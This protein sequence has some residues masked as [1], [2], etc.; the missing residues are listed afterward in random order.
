MAS[1]EAKLSFDQESQLYTLRS[2]SYSF[3]QNIRPSG[4]PGSE[5]Y[6]GTIHC[7]WEDDSDEPDESL[8]TW[9]SKPREYRNGSIKFMSDREQD[10]TYRELTFEKATIVQFTSNF[11]S[12]GQ[13][14]TCSFTISA[15][16]IKIGSV[17]YENQRWDTKRA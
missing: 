7:E 4:E 16:K 6:G 14:L 10:Q 12:G 9:A 5:V 8:L 1:F 13:G 11:S 3:S 17:E 2:C 15:Q